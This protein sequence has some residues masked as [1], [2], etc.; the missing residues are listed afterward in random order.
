[1][2]TESQIRIATKLTV[3]EFV[4]LYGDSEHVRHFNREG[5]V[6][7]LTRLETDQSESSEEPIDWTGYFISA[8]AYDGLAEMIV[9]QL[10]GS[11]LRVKRV[12][13]IEFWLEGRDE[14]L[15]FDNSSFLE[16]LTLAL[17]DPQFKAEVMDNFIETPIE[18]SSVLYTEDNK[19]IYLT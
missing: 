16:M 13:T 14:S 15:S 2:S 11:Q 12:E 1:M 3:D 19:V 7:I 18:W 5:I 17:G 4:K 9:E 10:D 8:M 6:A